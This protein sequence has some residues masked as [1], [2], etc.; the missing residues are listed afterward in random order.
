MKQ[1]L[2]LKCEV[3]NHKYPMHRVYAENTPTRLPLREFVSGIPMQAC[4]IVR[5]CVRICV[6]VLNQLLMLPYISFWI[7]CLSLANGFIE[8]I[9]VLLHSHT[10]P[11]SFLM[12]DWFYVLLI[13]NIVLLFIMWLSGFGQQFVVAP[14]QGNRNH[15][16]EE[17][18]EDAGVEQQ[19]IAGVKD[20]DLVELLL[21]VLIALLRCFRELIISIFRLAVH[22]PASRTFIYLF[23]CTAYFSLSNSVQHVLTVVGLIGQI[24]LLCLSW[25]FFAASSIFTP[26][27]KSAIYIENNSLKNA[28]PVITNSSAEIQNHSLLSCAIESLCLWSSLSLVSLEEILHQRYITI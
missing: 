1:R 16:A 19:A 28:S 10:S 22:D 14:Q 17:I 27:I 20:A 5:L 11:S 18:G 21:T 4:R 25:L 8:G 26:S 13:G 24:I 3:C 6:L 7:W 15:N 23:T 9:R 12:M 2:T